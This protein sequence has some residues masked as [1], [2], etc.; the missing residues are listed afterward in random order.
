ML[1]VWRVL[2]LA[3]M[4]LTQS[5]TL[6]GYTV[7]KEPFKINVYGPQVRAGSIRNHIYF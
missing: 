4:C 1:Q 3:G 7:G 5:D 6:G 2:R